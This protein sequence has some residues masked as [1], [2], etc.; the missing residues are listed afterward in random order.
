MAGTRRRVGVGTAVAAVAAGYCALASFAPPFT[1]AA[2]TVTA[3]A[4][5]GLAVLAAHTVVARRQ[6]PAV[7]APARSTFRPWV[8]SIG[9]ACA[10]ELVTY[11]AGFS[12]RH[13]F[14]TLSSISDL[15]FHYQALK[16]AAFALWLALGWG[17]FRR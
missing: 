6:P 2:D 13:A 14:P 16:G 10:L 15:A 1:A 3:V 4:F 7:P 8:A 5:F 11:F 9:A 17:M 12:D